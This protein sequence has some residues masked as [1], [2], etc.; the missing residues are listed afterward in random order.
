MT[1]PGKIKDK[2]IIN[3]AQM[4]APWHGGQVKANDEL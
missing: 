3:K 2:F 4:Q 1:N